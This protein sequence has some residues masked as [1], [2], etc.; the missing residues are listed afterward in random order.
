MQGEWKESLRRT[1]EPGTK[2]KED[3]RWEEKGNVRRLKNRRH[4]ERGSERR[5]EETLLEEGG[6]TGS[7]AM[8]E[9][10]KEKNKN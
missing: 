8:E 6:E 1:G 10:K 7:A 5:G 4:E 2:D 3:E 9:R